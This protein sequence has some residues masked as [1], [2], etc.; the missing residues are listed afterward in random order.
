MKY[1]GVNLTNDLYEENYKTDQR[2]QCKDIPCS[3]IGRFNIAKMLVLLNSIYRFSATPIKVS[4][5]YLVEISK[6]IL[7]FLSRGRTPE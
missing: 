4:T 3:W 2:N 7:K 1:L 5:S 6:M